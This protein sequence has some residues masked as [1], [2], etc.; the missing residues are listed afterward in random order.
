MGVVEDKVIKNVFGSRGVY[1]YI[2]DMKT[3][4]ELERDEV[5]KTRTIAVP[6]G[7]IEGMA[8]RVAESDLTVHVIPSSRNELGELAASMNKTVAALRLMVEQMKAT[9][10]QVERSSSQMSDG[11]QTIAQV[12]AE[13]ARS[14]KHLIDRFVLE[15]PAGGSDGGAR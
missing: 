1:E 8:K 14:L 12:S 10:D 11:S 9:A 15:K 7:E 4:G 5:N 13:Q 2:K 3:V 6:V